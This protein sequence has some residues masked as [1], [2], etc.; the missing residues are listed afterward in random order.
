MS[1]ELTDNELYDLFMQKMVNDKI[2]LEDFREIVFKHNFPQ[3][4]FLKAYHEIINYEADLYKMKWL[5]P[6]V[7][8]ELES[9]MVLR[10]EKIK[11]LDDTSKN[12]N[13]IVE[14]EKKIVEQEALLKPL[15]DDLDSII[16][17]M[18]ERQ[19]N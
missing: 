13:E 12:Y 5:Q 3:Y 6:I 1:K 16:A 7:L 8:K 9:I 11:L 2:S 10:Q 15:A 19:K 14:L 4:K 18:K 17:R